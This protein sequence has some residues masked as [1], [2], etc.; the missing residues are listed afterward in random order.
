MKIS[1][2][3]I[4]CKKNTISAIALY[5]CAVPTKD[6]LMGL[7]AGIIV[8][9]FVGIFAVDFSAPLRPV[10][11][12]IV[13]L[14][15]VK[16]L[17]HFGTVLTNPDVAFPSGGNFASFPTPDILAHT[18]VRVIGF[19]SHEPLTV[20][21]S[22]TIVCFIG[23]TLSAFMALRFSN[24]SVMLSF[25]SAIIYGVS[26]HMV[27]RAP[28]HSWLCLL[29]AVPW[30]CRLCLLIPYQRA[31]LGQK[32][33][34]LSLTGVVI[35][36]MAA[37]LSGLYLAF[38]SVLFLGMTLIVLLIQHAPKKQLSTILIALGSTIATFVVVIAPTIWA[39]ISEGIQLPARNLFFQSLYGIHLPDVFLPRIPFITSFYND[40]T[41]QQNN[42]STE[43]NYTVL[44]LWG[45]AGLIYGLFI[46]MRRLFPNLQRPCQQI[47]RRASLLYTAS[48]LTVFG[49]L[50]AIPYG[51][52]MIFNMLFSSTI[53]SQNRIGVFLL[54]FTLM[55]AAPLFDK[56]RL[57]MSKHKFLCIIG[58]VF[59][60]T[61]APSFM[62]V[63]RDQSIS[64]TLWKTRAASIKNVLSTLDKNNLQRVAQFPSLYFPEAPSLPAFGNTEH[65][66]PYILDKNST[67]KW[68][69]GS[70]L[71]DNL[72]QNLIAAWDA[73]TESWLYEMRFMGYD[74]ALI[75]KKALVRNDTRRLEDLHSP[76]FSKLI[77]F[78][79][80]E[81]ILLQVPKEAI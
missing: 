49:I 81:R 59:I 13:S 25:A 31:R 41:A 34:Q 2:K 16:S 22:Y 79:D 1:K 61:A 72:W 36:G 46:C 28:L 35:A 71:Q 62:A 21:I 37:G 40:Y 11:D 76:K 19:F 75:E 54:F 48:F 20:L 12:Y 69:F 38:F 30:I 14:F 39:I 56:M 10:G 77:L 32:P 33:F 4:E 58:I 67:R 5:K 64:L 29:I 9:W 42:I 6:L 55:M 78:E 68:S 17:L 74:A 8:T 51:L 53:R 23:V 66:W 65:L 57:N 80:N 47:I 44:G 43:G 70:M 3:Q 15:N 7:L 50:F 18:I 63:S 45:L 73:P 24:M 60:L 26:A 52:G 27:E